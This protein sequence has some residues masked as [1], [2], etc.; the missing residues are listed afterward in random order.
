MTWLRV[1]IEVVA[2]PV[3]VDRQQGDGI[4][5]VLLAVGLGLDEQHFLGQSVRGVG[6]LRIAVPEFLFLE[7]HR[8]ELGIGADGAEA[9]VFLDAAAGAPPP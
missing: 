1:E 6:L 5:A 7:R 2:R 9:D 4:E 3:Q 8:R